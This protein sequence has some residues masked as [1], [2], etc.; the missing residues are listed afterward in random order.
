M[1]HRPTRF[2]LV[3][4]NSGSDLVFFFRSFLKTRNGG[5]S[6]I[7]RVADQISVVHIF[8]LNFNAAGRSHFDAR[9]N[10]ILQNQME[11]NCLCVQIKTDQAIKYY[12][13]ATL[14]NVT[15]GYCN[16]FNS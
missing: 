9:W 14:G 2:Y 5:C 13:D 4:K 15:K 1:G 12:L 6:G 7:Y 16:Q 8:L 10:R 3:S 11:G